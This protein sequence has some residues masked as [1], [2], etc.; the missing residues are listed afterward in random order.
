MPITRRQGNGQADP[1]IL[2]GVITLVQEDR[3]M[4]QCDDG[5]YRLFLLAHDCPA[6][7]TELQQAMRR[8]V[9]VVV[10]CDE[11]GG[12]I[13]AR[14]RRLYLADDQPGAPA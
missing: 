9:R 12:V 7:G 10:A 14:A 1:Q 6:E 3:F 8:Q 2:R 13:A 4:L 11:A 5:S